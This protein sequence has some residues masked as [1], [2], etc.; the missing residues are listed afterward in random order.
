[1]GKA[2]KYGHIYDPATGKLIN[3]GQ[4]CNKKLGTIRGWNGAEMT[5]RQFG[6]MS[7]PRYRRGKVRRRY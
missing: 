4:K 1:M 5:P 2:S 7:R 3:C 6:E